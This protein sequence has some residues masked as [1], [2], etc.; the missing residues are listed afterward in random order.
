MWLLARLRFV[1][2]A[3]ILI[4]GGMHLAPRVADG[5]LLREPPE[6]GIAPTA[7]QQV[8]LPAPETLVGRTSQGRSAMG[9]IR[10]ARVVAIGVEWAPRCPGGS[11]LPV[12]RDGFRDAYAGDFAR[13]GRHFEDHYVSD[14]LRAELVG[15][16]AADGRS[17]RGVV[18]FTDERSGCS[19]GPVTWEAHA[20]A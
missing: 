10:E 9:L 1:A 5:S 3:A 20:T 11:M 18:R 15:Q 4:A 6:A 16:A 14:G 7:Q 8:S 19:S 17:A 2:Y 12:R 13:H